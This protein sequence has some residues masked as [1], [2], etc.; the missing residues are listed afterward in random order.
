MRIGAE[1]KYRY[2]KLR[3]KPACTIWKAGRVVIRSTPYGIWAA[4]HTSK[5]SILW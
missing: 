5:I 3:E 1:G 2:P 4:A